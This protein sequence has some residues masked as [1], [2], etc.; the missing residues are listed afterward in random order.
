MFVFYNYFIWSHLCSSIMHAYWSENHKLIQFNYILLFT[1]ISQNEMI[2][3][4]NK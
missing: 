4:K 3:S 1:R 2:Y